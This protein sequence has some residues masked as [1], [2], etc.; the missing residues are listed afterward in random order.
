MKKVREVI[1][2]MV[3]RIKAA[4]GNQRVLACASV[5]HNPTLT[6]RRRAERPTQHPHSDSEMYLKYYT[7]LCQVNA[8]TL[9]PT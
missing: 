4:T 3:L 2:E 7:L 6:V 5:D 1:A 8:C 9:Q